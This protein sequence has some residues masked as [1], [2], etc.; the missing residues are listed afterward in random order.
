MNKIILIFVLFFTQNIF[1]FESCKNVRLVSETEYAADKIKWDSLIKKCKDDN[2]QVVADF[3]LF[4]TN[5]KESPLQN[6]TGALSTIDLLNEVG[7][8]TVKHIE[9]NVK[10][11]DVAEKCLSSKTVNQSDL[12]LMEKGL[13]CPQL[14]EGMKLRFKEKMPELRHELS[15][16]GQMNIGDMDY[17]LTKL[18]SSKLLDPSLNR[19]GGLIG[20]GVLHADL[21][22]QSKEEIEKTKKEFDQVLLGIKK[23]FEEAKKSKITEILSKMGLKPADKSYKSLYEMHARD[24][25]KNYLSYGRSKLQEFQKKKEMSYMNV[26]GSSPF[27]LY[28]GSENPSNDDFLKTIPKLRKSA[29]EELGRSKEALASAS[30][31]LEK[32]KKFTRGNNKQKAIDD[33]MYFFG[34]TPVIEEVLSE[35]NKNCATAMGLK[36]FIQKESQANQLMIMG[37]LF[38]GAYLFATRA[39]A[40]LTLMTGM[41]WSPTAAG[42]IFWDIFWCCF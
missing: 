40:I 8:R 17:A 6:L 9:N 35:N 19:S 32:M 21:A 28:I 24:E 11:L 31:S 7:N 5:V 34:N 37:G 22:K 15:F 39:P 20:G 42:A 18:D 1:A 36:N 30:V 16:L 29:L 41:S 12:D 26:A 23:S 14:F 13:T 27:L 33:L 10:S 38:G 2:I 25:D 3:S 4:S